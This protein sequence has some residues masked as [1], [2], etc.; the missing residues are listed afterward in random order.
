MIRHLGRSRPDL[1]RLRGRHRLEMQAPDVDPERL[2][3]L[4]GR[5]LYRIV[6]ALPDVRDADF[7]VLV[8][9]DH[10]TVLGFGIRVEA[11]GWDRDH[12]GDASDQEG[13]AVWLRQPPRGSIAAALIAAQDD[14]GAS[15]GTFRIEHPGSGAALVEDHGYRFRSEDGDFSAHG[16]TGGGRPSCGVTSGKVSMSRVGSRDPSCRAG[17]WHCGAR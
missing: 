10:P 5:V 6:P 11:I 1:I 3:L 13:R 7:R 14:I 2:K 15:L 16:D 8:E 17:G 9:R 12:I 4:K